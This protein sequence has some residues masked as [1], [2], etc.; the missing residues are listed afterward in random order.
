[1]RQGGM[2]ETQKENT[3]G[4]RALAQHPQLRYFENF[5]LLCEIA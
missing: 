4:G 5:L 3:N 1:M 2:Q